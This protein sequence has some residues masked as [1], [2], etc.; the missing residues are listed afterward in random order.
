MK[1]RTRRID[2]HKQKLATQP[3]IEGKR[4]RRKLKNLAKVPS[5][6]SCPK[7]LDDTLDQ[8]LLHVLF[9]H[10]L[11]GWIMILRGND[12]C[13]G[14]AIV[15]RVAFAADKREE[16]A[17]ECRQRDEIEKGSPD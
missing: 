8:C 15:G 13:A 3:E 5:G 10:G 14:E 7:L 17:D 4:K 16:D 9:N 11:D 2:A 1:T 12:C 6:Q